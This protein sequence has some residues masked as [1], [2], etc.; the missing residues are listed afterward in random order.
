MLKEKRSAAASSLLLLLLRAPE[1]VAAQAATSHAEQMVVE[2]S[3]AASRAL[4]DK[5]ALNTINAK[6]LSLASDSMLADVDDGRLKTQ[7]EKC[8]LKLAT[9]LGNDDYGLPSNLQ[10]E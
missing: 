8:A 3:S 4:P 5:T 9:L 2:V 10:G 7:L 6:V 1:A